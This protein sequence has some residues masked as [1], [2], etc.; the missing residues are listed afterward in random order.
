MVFRHRELTF[1][2]HAVASKGKDDPKQELDL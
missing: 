2:E 1:E